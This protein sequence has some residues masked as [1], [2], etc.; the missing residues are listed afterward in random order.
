MAILRAEAA[1]SRPDRQ[2]RNL[3]MKANLKSQL[4]VPW[5]L[6]SSARINP[7]SRFTASLRVPA[8]PD[9]WDYLRDLRQAELEAWNEAHRSGTAPEYASVA[10]GLIQINQRSQT[11]SKIMLG[12]AVVAAAAVAYALWDSTEIVGHWSQFVKFVGQLL[13]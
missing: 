1:S 3:V 6:K 11:E 7:T 12:I 4:G 10:Q 9:N 2:K 8:S 13:A 5:L